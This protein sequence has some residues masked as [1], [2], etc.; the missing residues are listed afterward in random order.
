M[1]LK[2]WFIFLMISTIGVL[3]SLANAPK[4][5]EYH[6]LENQQSE[7]NNTDE[8]YNKMM[9]VLTHQRCMNYHP[10]DNIHK[11]GNDLHSHYFGME[12]GEDDKG[13]QATICNACHNSENNKYSG[14]PRAPHWS[15]APAS[16]GWEGLTRSQ[17][18]ERLVDKN[19]YGQRSFDELVKHMTEDELVLWAWSPGIDTN[20]QEREIPPVSKEEFKN[21]V[22]YW[23]DNGA[24][25]P[26]K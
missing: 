6:L 7:I 25:I 5:F 16:M 12:R 14:V 21:V 18:P 22:E 8:A 10:N 20:D 11:Q 1:K 24:V 2:T 26:T 19:V 9:D 13:F 17:I 23:F 4:I 3:L 15:L